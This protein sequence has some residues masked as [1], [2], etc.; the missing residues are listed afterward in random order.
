MIEPSGLT[1]RTGRLHGNL[2][3]VAR[4]LLA[5]LLGLYALTALL[6]LALHSDRY[7]WDFRS[8]YYAG[9]ALREGLNPY[10]LDSLSLVAGKE[11]GF[12]FVYSPL[13][14]PLLS[15]VSRLPFATAYCLFL[16]AKVVALGGLLWLWSSF[17]GRD[18][19]LLFFLLCAFGFGGTIFADLAAG[20][21]S[22]F[23]QVAL[24]G[25][26]VALARGR[27]AWF[28]LLVILASV[29]K[30][31]PIAF[32]VLLIIPGE[33][34][35]PAMFLGATGAFVGLQGLTYLL[36]PGLYR[37]FLLTTTQLDDRGIINP[38]VLALLRDLSDL[39]GGKGVRV[40]ASGVWAVYAAFACAVVLVMWRL[41]RRNRPSD[42]RVTVVLVC[43]AFAL[44]MPRFKNYA[45]I[46]LL[47]PSYFVLRKMVAGWSPELGL[48]LLML[49]GS[50]ALPLG[51]GGVASKVFWNY[52]AWLV[53]LALWLIAVA[54][55]NRAASAEAASL[56]VV[57]RSRGGE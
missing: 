7:Q 10:E 3:K 54:W 57:M 41:F 47:P 45:Y 25:G 19:D 43:L 51:L 33:R 37:D 13:V 14:L 31:T 53:T 17:L 2:S 26:F 38:S 1:A 22:I 39:L 55:H 40:P 42:Q 15:W 20:N 52:Y 8:Y 32:L 49:S 46:L 50:P 23:E 16:A 35:R 18:A 12:P 48:V 36:G 44:I 21:I 6:D 29:F 56:E 4:P 28:S 30:L 24:W 34:A 5:G 9:R 27:P 11:I